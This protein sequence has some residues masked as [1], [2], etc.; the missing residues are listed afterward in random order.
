MLVTCGWSV[1][2]SMNFCF[3]TDCIGTKYTKFSGDTDC[4]G[5]KFS[6]D[7]DCI[8]T[9]FS[10]DTDCIGTKFSGDTDC[11]GTL[12]LYNQCLH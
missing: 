4:I 6:G 8:G 3:Y 11:I 5:T 9:K 2:F 10:G 1:F 7:T 12:Y